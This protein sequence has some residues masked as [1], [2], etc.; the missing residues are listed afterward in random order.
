MKQDFTE[1]VAV[2]EGITVEA[3]ANS[4]KIKG[5]K[6]ELSRRFVI[7]KISI[8]AKDGNV[9]LSS[10]SA[11]KREKSKLYATRAHINN[12]LKGVQA[13]FVYV[14]KICSGHFPMNVSLAGSKLSVK[15]FLGEKIPRITEIPQGV[16]V[17]IEGDKITVTSIDTE[18]GGRTSSNIE[19]LTRIARRDRR[20][21]QDGIYIIQKPEA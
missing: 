3:S 2:P 5:P 6:G 1:T 10:K 14:L 16:A 19:Q 13:P 7:P 4:V 21:F 20:I 11:T 9:I 15:N 17:K 18:L 12:M 8:E